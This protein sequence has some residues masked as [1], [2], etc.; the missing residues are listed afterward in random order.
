MIKPMRIL[1]Y[2][3]RQLPPP[4]LSGLGAPPRFCPEAAPFWENL[5]E[6][7][8]YIPS[9]AAVKIGAAPGGLLLSH[10]NHATISG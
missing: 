6:L 2:S 9:V 8:K 4:Q 7:G 3:R 5:S 1:V 10:F